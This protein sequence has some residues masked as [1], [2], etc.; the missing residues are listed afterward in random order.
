MDG[1]VGYEEGP[2]NERSATYRTSDG[3]SLTS[4]IRV[5][6]RMPKGIIARV[7]GLLRWL[8]YRVVEFGNPGLPA[9]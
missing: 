4:I 3:L 1:W 8:L 9:T 6:H 5:N 2:K 7:G